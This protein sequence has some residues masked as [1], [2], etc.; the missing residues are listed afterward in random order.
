MISGQAAVLGARFIL[1]SA[2]GTCGQ[3]GQDE[4]PRGSGAFVLRRS[5]AK[6]SP[7]LGPGRRLRAVSTFAPGWMDVG[8]RGT[9]YFRYAM[10]VGRGVGVGGVVAEGSVALHKE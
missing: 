10:G 3:D 2:R 1:D 8:W 5:R 9:Q 6:V 4:A 7:A